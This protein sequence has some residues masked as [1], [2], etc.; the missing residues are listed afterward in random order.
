MLGRRKIVKPCPHEGR[1]HLAHD[2]STIVRPH[3]Q[4]LTC[5]ARE[6]GYIVARAD[7]DHASA[8]LASLNAAPADAMVRIVDLDDGTQDACPLDEFLMSNLEALDASDV[9]RLLE[10]EVITFGGGAQPATGVQLVF[11]HVQRDFDAA[12]CEA[13]DAAGAIDPMLDKM[14]GEDKTPA[15]LARAREIARLLTAT[16][17]DMRRV[18]GG[19]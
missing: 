6:Q 13:Y 3:L 18:L 19:A 7:R 8:L 12:L 15:D 4:A 16:V 17:A 10:G 14:G 2:G 5:F 11:P 1:Y 9:A